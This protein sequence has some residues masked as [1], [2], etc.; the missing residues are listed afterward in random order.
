[1]NR[2]HTAWLS[3]RG[4]SAEQNL[5]KRLKHCKIGAP[6]CSSVSHKVFSG[7]QYSIFLKEPQNLRPHFF[8]PR[9]YALAK[10]V[11]FQ[12][13]SGLLPA[14]LRAPVH[15]CTKTGTDTYQ[16]CQG[17]NCSRMILTVRVQHAVGKYYLPTQNIYKE[18]TYPF[19]CFFNTIE[20]R[21]LK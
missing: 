7:V 14:T 6:G 15:F 17:M 12:C 3:T 18:T 11:T 8:L 1:M 10:E 9:Q 19:V 13:S 21:Q 16:V 5:Q 20:Q 2:L 4:E